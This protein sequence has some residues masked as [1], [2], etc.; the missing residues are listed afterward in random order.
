MIVWLVAVEIVRL[1]PEAADAARAAGEA[2]MA[3]QYARE[4]AI[5]D[6]PR[7]RRGLFAGG[8]GTIPLSREHAPLG[9]V[10]QSGFVY[11]PGSI[12]YDRYRDN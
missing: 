4:D 1:S 6:R 5:R 11:L 2:R 12:G 9:D 10:G 3:A 8:I 7:P